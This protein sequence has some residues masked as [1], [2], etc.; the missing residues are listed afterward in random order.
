VER[1][2]H[3]FNESEVKEFREAF[4]TFDA[5]KS[6]AISTEEL[7]AVLKEV[8]EETSAEE[9]MLMVADVDFDGD[10]EIDF[11]EFLV[12]MTRKSKKVRIPRPEHV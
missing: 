8:G 11:D 3:S 12:M 1:Q 4:D 6:G 10:G 5:D 2:L 9:V 7:G